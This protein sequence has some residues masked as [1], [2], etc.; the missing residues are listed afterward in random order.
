MDDGDAKQIYTGKN[1]AV[2]DEVPVIPMVADKV[3]SIADSL[4]GYGVYE[5][6]DAAV[7]ADIFGLDIADVSESIRQFSDVMKRLGI[8]LSGDELYEE[9]QRIYDESVSRDAGKEKAEDKVWNRD[10]GR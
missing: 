3:E 6:I 4:S 5:D 9:F 10:R 7:K 1:V 8:R 2:D